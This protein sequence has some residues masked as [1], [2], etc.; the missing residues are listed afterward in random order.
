M[1]TVMV[2]LAGLAPRCFRGACQL[3]AVQAAL[4]SSLTAGSPPALLAYPLGTLSL[5]FSAA[6][7][8]PGAGFLPPAP[9]VVD[10]KKTRSG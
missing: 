4:C 5:P 6:A 1:G 7:G 9:A 3:D 8:P 10:L 2:L